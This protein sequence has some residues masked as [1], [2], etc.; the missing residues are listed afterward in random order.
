MTEHQENTMAAMEEEISAL[1]SDL[2]KAKGALRF[3]ADRKHWA[4]EW[5]EGS[6]E[7]YG[8]I[9]RQTLAELGEK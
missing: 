6:H 9:A 1:K 2:E 7:D 5:V 3:Y 8:T 4:I